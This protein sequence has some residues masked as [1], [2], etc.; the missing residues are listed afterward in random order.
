MGRRVTPA[1]STQN[2]P[3]GKDD[4]DEHIDRILGSDSRLK[5]TMV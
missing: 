5:G 2:H 3:E 1:T 4:D